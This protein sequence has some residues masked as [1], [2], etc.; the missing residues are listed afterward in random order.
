MREF[1]KEQKLQMLKFMELHTLA[2]LILSAKECT[3]EMPD[4][5]IDLINGLDEAVLVEIDKICI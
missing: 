5:I 3:N 1:D 2:A 4:S